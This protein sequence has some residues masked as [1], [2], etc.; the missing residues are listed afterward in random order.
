M[1]GLDM[2]K[3]LALPVPPQFSGNPQ[4]HNAY[5]ALMLIPLSR[6]EQMQ[7]IKDY[8]HATP[9]AIKVSQALEEERLH[10]NSN[11]HIII[12]QER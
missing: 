12:S 9:T 3:L 7:I 11:G 6:E 2:Y 4:Y 5:Q 8:S 1:N 10:W